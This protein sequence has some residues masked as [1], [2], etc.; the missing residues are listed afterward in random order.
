MSKI[1]HALM[2][3][4]KNCSLSTHPYSCWKTSPCFQWPKTKNVCMW[5]KRMEKAFYK[6]CERVLRH[7][8]RLFFFFTD[9]GFRGF[10]VGFL[11]QLWKMWLVICF[12]MT[13]MKPKLKHIGL[14]VKSFF[15]LHV[16]LEFWPFW[17]Q[18]VS[19]QCFIFSLVCLGEKKIVATLF[20]RVLFYLYSFLW[21]NRIHQY[22]S[23]VV[24]LMF[25]CYC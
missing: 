3:H 15:I 9:F 1:E 16:L 24:C 4:V 11:A 10:V 13:L 17:F 8:R 25:S 20:V 5:P 18:P 7:T 6:M 22:F 2:F 23:F 19:H 14:T 21:L 12:M